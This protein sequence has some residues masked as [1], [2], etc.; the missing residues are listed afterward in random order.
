MFFVFFVLGDSGGFG[1][2]VLGTGPLSRLHVKMLCCHLYSSAFSFFSSG[3]LDSVCDSELSQSIELYEKRMIKCCFVW[4]RDVRDGLLL[5]KLGRNTYRLAL[6]CESL[7]F[8]FVSCS[9]SLA[10]IGV[11]GFSKLSSDLVLS[12]R[13]SMT[14]P[15]KYDRI[16]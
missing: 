7:S 11:I 2:D 15:K 16:K 8:V 12:S 14:T 6:L 9:S 5:N 10:T 1:V 3:S 4:R 13:L